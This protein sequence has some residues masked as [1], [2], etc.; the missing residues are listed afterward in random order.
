M[1]GNIGSHVPCAAEL[2]VAGVLERFG[3]QQDVHAETTVE[4]HGA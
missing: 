1:V 2:K 3:C 4:S